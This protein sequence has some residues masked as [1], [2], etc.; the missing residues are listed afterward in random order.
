M[1]HGSPKRCGSGR[2]EARSPPP[3]EHERV[4]MRRVPVGTGLC[5]RGAPISCAP[6]GRAG[7]GKRHSG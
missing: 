7:V 6:P 3:L 2:S 1:D 4:P 5:S